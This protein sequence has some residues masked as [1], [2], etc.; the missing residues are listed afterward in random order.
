MEWHRLPDAN[1]MW[2]SF[3]LNFENA[4]TELQEM[5]SAAQYLNYGAGIMANVLKTLATVTA[6]DCQAVANLSHTSVLL[7]DQV[8]NLSKK[9][10]KKDTQIDD[11]C[12]SISDLTMTI[13]SLAN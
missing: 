12:K 11:L 7:N 13:W 5:Q 3:K 1:K 8:A 9:V 4:H 6:D 10:T 2:Q